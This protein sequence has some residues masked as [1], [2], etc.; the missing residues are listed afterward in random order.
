VTFV[1]V[2][3][4]EPM[5][6]LVAVAEQRTRRGIAGELSHITGDLLARSHIAAARLIRTIASLIPYAQFIFDHLGISRQTGHLA[7]LAGLACP[8]AGLI[9]LPP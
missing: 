7:A 3:L 6:V 5:L 2:W 8:P 1:I 9:T 4:S